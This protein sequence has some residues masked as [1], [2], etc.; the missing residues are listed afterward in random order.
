MFFFSSNIGNKGENKKK[1]VKMFFFEKFQLFPGCFD[2]LDFIVFF[3]FFSK[4]ISIF[5][6]SIFQHWNSV[7]ASPATPRGWLLQS[8]NG[9]C[10]KI[11]KSRNFFFEFFYFFPSLIFFM[12]FQDFF[13]FL[14]KLVFV[15]FLFFIFLSIRTQQEP[16]PRGRQWPLQSVPTEFVCRHSA[17]Q[18]GSSGRHIIFF[19]CISQ[20]KQT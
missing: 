19:Q 14:Q 6:S 2:V 1:I 11:K 18:G 4:K 17:K 5:S 7:G 8:Y 3:L 12:I 20:Q 16:A 15:N 13:D 10:K 9:K